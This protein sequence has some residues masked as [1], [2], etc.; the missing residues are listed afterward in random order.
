MGK[1][2]TIL[3]WDTQTGQ[4]KT[5]LTGHLDTVNS[6][7]F[8]PDGKTLASGSRDETIRLWD[9]ST[10]ELRLTFA[11]HA[12]GVSEVI[13]SPDGK[14]LASHGGDEMMRLW[15]AH[16]G[17]FIRTLTGQT[18]YS[19]ADYIYSIAYS[20]DG[21]ILASGIDDGTIQLWGTDTGHLK[22][23]LKHTTDSN[24]VVP[25]VFSPDGLTLMSADRADDMIR[26][27]DVSTGERLK[28]IENP[29]DTTNNILFSPDGNTYASAGGDGDNSFL[30]CGNHSSDKNAQRVC[31]YV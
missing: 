27:W 24:G 9:V 18:D 26:F 3:L 5:T 7:A 28:T 8:S 19:Q 1:E 6:V 16:T 4:L 11:G 22:M 25:V 17:K 13:Y 14:M 21:K 10:G 31:G 2:N 29:P 20:P 15:N 12:D 23:T 30:G